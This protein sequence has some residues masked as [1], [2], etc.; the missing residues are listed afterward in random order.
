M[1]TWEAGVFW[2]HNLNIIDSESWYSF[3]LSQVYFSPQIKIQRHDNG[4]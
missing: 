2:H 3:R 4:S 1:L